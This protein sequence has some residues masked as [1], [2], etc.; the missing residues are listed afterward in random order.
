MLR[1][2]YFIGL[3]GIITLNVQAQGD[4]PGIYYSEPHRP[5]YHFTP[6]AKWMNDPNGMV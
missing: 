4:F 2:I 6:P 1:W 3:M 5:Q